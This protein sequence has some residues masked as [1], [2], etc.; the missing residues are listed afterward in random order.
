MVCAPTRFETLAKDKLKY[1]QKWK[2]NP[3][4]VV[5]IMTNASKEEK[6]VRIELKDKGMERGASEP[7]ATLS[8]VHK[9]GHKSRQKDEDHF[10]ALIT[11][12]RYHERAHA[13]R[14]CKRSKQG[15]GNGKLFW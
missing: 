15:G 6:L 10:E 11:C 7:T 8:K 2:E 4:K 12:C 14:Q 5:Q 13:L 1:I 9:A 3:G